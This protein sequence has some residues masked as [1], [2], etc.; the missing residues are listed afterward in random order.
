MYF[1]WLLSRKLYRE[2]FF[3]KGVRD[4]CSS[5]RD[6]SKGRISGVL[7]T[8]RS[9]LRREGNANERRCTLGRRSSQ[10]APCSRHRTSSL[11]RRLTRNLWIGILC[12]EEPKGASPVFTTPRGSSREKTL[13]KKNNPWQIFFFFFFLLLL[14]GAVAAYVVAA[15]ARLHA[16]LGVRERFVFGS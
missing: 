12:H 13:I 4:T 6:A 8:S 10:C 5:L 1:G 3:W 14:L 7:E 9:V 16:R 2:L 11:E 15:G